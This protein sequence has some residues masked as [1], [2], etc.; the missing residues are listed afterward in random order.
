MSEFFIDGISGPLTIAHD[1]EF[2]FSV[3]VVNTG[4]SFGSSSVYFGDDSAGVSLGPFEA[5]TVTLRPSGPPPGERQNT[6][7]GTDD[8][9]FFENLRREEEPEP[10]PEPGESELGINFVSTF[11]HEDDPNLVGADVDLENRVTSGEGATLSDTAVVTVNGETVHTETVEL[12]PG[13][14]TQL[15]LDLEVE[16]GEAEI[17]AEYGGEKTCSTETAGE[18]KSE[19][20]ISN[21]TAEA[22]GP[23]EAVV[24]VSVNNEIVA[25]PGSDETR[26]V[27]VE[28]NGE[29]V[30][31]DTVTVIAADAETVTFELDG[32][33]EGDVEICASL[34]E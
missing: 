8:D 26:I 34:S 14:T 18:F 2:E 31:S 33:P 25:G 22:A 15:V 28:A 12:G 27:I 20:S 4:D 29:Q 30:A 5:A 1:E 6:A 9:E 21:V 3:G 24:Q 23:H 32:L 11:V 7:V 19:M 16:T 10:E 17:C 13:A